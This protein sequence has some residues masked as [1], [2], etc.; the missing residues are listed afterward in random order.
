MS[1]SLGTTH[2]SCSHNDDILHRP[3]TTL[4]CA[5]GIGK[6]KETRDIITGDQKT[7]FSPGDGHAIFNCLNAQVLSR[8]TNIPV[9]T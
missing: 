2:A 9:R 1:K 3:S 4:L 5:L 7:V 6:G 8:S